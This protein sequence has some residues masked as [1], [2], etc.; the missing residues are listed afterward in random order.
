MSE[1]YSFQL[2]QVEEAL[3]KDPSNADLQ[4]M[5]RDLLELISLMGVAAAQSASNTQAPKPKRSHFE[6]EQDSKE[7]EE[8]VDVRW[9]KNQ[10]VLAKYKDG[11]MYEAVVDSVPSAAQ[12]AHY[13]VVFKGYT[14]KEK[15]LV[16]NV[17]DFDPTQVAKPLA[18]VAGGTLNKRNPTP[19]AV[20]AAFSNGTDRASKRKK[21]NL[22]YHEHITQKEVEHSVKQSAW[23]QFASGSGS[24]KSALKTTAPLKKTSMFATPEDPTAKVATR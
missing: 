2:A 16:E 14:S 23:K 9:V 17:R 6:V 12:P 18:A 21:N 5:Q 10:T 19:K 3:S 7:K 4:Q 24:K 22:E 1:D 13:T 15:V 20:A 11:K 8:E